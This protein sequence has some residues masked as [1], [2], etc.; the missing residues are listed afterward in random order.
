MAGIAL[1]VLIIAT[2]PE[3][4]TAWRPDEIPAVRTM[5]ALGQTVRM[6]LEALLADAAETG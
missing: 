1:A 4:D 6:T 5:Q 3:I 2:G